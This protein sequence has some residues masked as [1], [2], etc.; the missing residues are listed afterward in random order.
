[1]LIPSSNNYERSKAFSSSKSHFCVSNSQGSCW[2]LA[3]APLVDDTHLTLEPSLNPNF[4]AMLAKELI[5]H[6]NR[7]CRTANFADTAIMFTVHEHRLAK[8]EELVRAG[9]KCMEMSW[10]EI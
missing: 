8:V 9:D 7:H 4:M 5:T 10:D 3:K 6:L 2:A 1:M